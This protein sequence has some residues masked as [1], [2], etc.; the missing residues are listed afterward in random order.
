M[1]KVG[2]EGKGANRSFRHHED[3]PR[4]AMNAARFP[5]DL[6]LTLFHAYRA[7]FFVLLFWD[8]DGGRP[9]LFRGKLIA[10]VLGENLV[11]QHVDYDASHGYV[12]PNG[13]SPAGDFLV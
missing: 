1:E 5:S 9:S 2:G 4:L 10:G 11:K 12:H 3:W 6:D 7:A 13:P 8:P